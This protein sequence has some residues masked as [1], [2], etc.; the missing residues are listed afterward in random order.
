MVMVRKTSGIKRYAG[1]WAKRTEDAFD[2]LIQ[3]DSRTPMV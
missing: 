3:I 1:D 2:E